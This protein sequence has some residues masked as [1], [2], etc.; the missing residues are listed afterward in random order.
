[1][2]RTHDNMGPLDMTTIYPDTTADPEN[3]ASYNFTAADTAFGML[4]EAGF[5][6]YWRVGYSMVSIDEWLGGCVCVCMRVCVC[7]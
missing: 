7:L 5:D 2:L 1:M 4:V 3:A 6:I